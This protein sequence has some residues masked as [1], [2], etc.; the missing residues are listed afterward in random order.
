[1]PLFAYLSDD[2]ALNII[3]FLNTLSID[4]GIY[5]LIFF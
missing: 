5:F 4:S 3:V 1:M 2:E